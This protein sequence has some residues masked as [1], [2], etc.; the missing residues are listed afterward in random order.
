MHSDHA[1]NLS[2]DE[3]VSLSRVWKGVA[4]PD[5]H[6]RRLIFLNYIADLRGGR[7]ELTEAG[8][9]GRSRFKVPEVF[10][11]RD[12]LPSGPTGKADRRAVAG[13]AAQKT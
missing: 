11:F 2:E 13:L 9:R 1:S 8:R 12:A 10:H 4:I 6:R 3:L 7:L 5:D